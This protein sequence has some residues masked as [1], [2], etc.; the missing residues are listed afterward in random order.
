MIDEYV[1][2]LNFLIN[3]NHTL[4]FILRWSLRRFGL[5]NLSYLCNLGIK[6]MMLSREYSIHL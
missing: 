1:I 3:L 2:K 4:K 5:N 6:F